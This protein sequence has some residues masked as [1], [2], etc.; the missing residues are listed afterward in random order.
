MD[1]ETQEKRDKYRQTEEIK[2]GN[3]EKG[4][5]FSLSLCSAAAWEKEREGVLLLAVD[6]TVFE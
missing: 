4:R 5:D 3:R 2:G 1:R 6:V